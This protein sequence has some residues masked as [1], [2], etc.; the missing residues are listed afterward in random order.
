MAIMKPGYHKVSACGIVFCYNE[1]AILNDT[2]DYYLSQGINLVVFNNASNDLSAE[3][4]SAFQK[5]NGLHQGRLIDV[6]NIQTQGYEW[7]KILKAG[8]DYMHNRL[9]GYNWILN[10]DADAFY[11]SPIK[12]MPLLEFIALAQKYGYNVLNGMLLE[13][14]P[15]KNDEVAIP[16]PVK[17]LSYF[18]LK[19]R[20]AFNIAKYHKIFRYHPSVNFYST[21][22]HIILRDKIRVLEKMR[23]I[24]KHY[25]W[26]SFEHGVKKIFQDR[27][28]R[29]VE[30]K[31]KPIWHW[32]WLG[33][34]PIEQDLLRDPAG[35]LF[36]RPQ[37]YAISRPK[38]FL[39]MQLGVF[40]DL[41]YWILSG[42]RLVIELIKWLSVFF[43]NLFRGAG[44]MLNA[45]FFGSIHKNLQLI[46]RETKKDV[47]SLSRYLAKKYPDKSLIEKLKLKL[48]M[49]YYG[50]L[51]FQEPVAFAN[52]SIYHFLMTNFCNT[53]CVFC[54][55]N[56]T[57]SAKQEITLDSYKQMLDNIP[58]D[59]AKAFF[60]SGGGEP[61]L[62]RDLFPIIEFVNSSFPWIDVHVRTNGILIQEYIDELSNLN[63]SRLE[64][65]I[66]GTEA[67]NDS[68]IQ[69]KVTR[70]IFKGLELLNSRLDEKGKKL[71]KVFYTALNRQNINNLLGLMEK[72]AQ[73]KVSEISVSFCRFYPGFEASGGGK[74]KKA[75]S[76]F[77]HQELYNKK[78]K[79]A[80]KLAKRLKIHFEHE[81]FFFQKLNPK[82][83]RIPWQSIVIDSDGTVYP[84]TGGEVCF[85]Q[86][87]RNKE[88][89]FGNLLKEQLY[90][91]WNNNSYIMIRRTCNPYRK[92]NLIPECRSCHNTVCFEGPGKE[93][94]HFLPGDSLT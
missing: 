66:H 30:R 78:I 79:E 85:K 43:V 53:R 18:E 45:L 91:L 56:H 65:S 35:L 1:E 67:V 12:G 25:P 92:E 94:G 86:K 34:L 84:C 72:A 59:S 90:Q 82:T 52:P 62:C 69:N 71:S 47:S 54:N 37:A 68:L 13:F 16:S 24:Y 33:M 87:V 3:I 57:V 63:I 7:H 21:G 77:Y 83:C 73:L 29:Y 89:Y 61:L 19:K 31:E 80:E 93:R 17:R 41:Y 76:L 81:P 4:I 9:S 75:D 50:S 5:N 28:P 10:I 39:I 49:L 20:E 42:L 2:L 26:V 38:F 64:I 40:S 44:F 11:V 74:L 36:F 60:F 15:T 51:I 55:Q 32:H 58:T 70:E 88:Y 23:F 22:G 48:N 27:R 8:C 6:V 14:Y 46:F